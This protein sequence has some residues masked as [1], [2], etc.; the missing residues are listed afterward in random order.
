MSDRIPMIPPFRVVSRVQIL[1]EMMDYNHQMMNVPAMWRDTMGALKDGTGVPVVI[2]DTGIPNH[3]DLKPAGGKSFIPG[4]ERDLNGHGTHVAGIVAAIANNSMGVAGIAPD[5]DDW[6]GAVL[7]EQGSGEISQIVAGIRWA[8]DEVG[9]KVISMSLGI[10]DGY[11]IFPELEKAVNYAN[12]QGVA[13]ICAAGNEASGVGQPACYDSTIAVAA[14]NSRKEKAW[15]SN[16]GS[17]IDFAAGGVDI[18]S[19]YL[20]NG[21][22][23]LSGTSMSAPAL[24]GVATLILADEKNDHGKWLTPDE[25]MEKMKRISY[26]VGGDGFDELY[27]NGIPMFR[28][29]IGEPDEPEANPEPPIEQPQPNPPNAKKS[30][31]PC[32]LTW[33]VLKAFSEG[34][35]RAA[36]DGA[37]PDGAILAGLSAAGKFAGM[38]NEARNSE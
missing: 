37:D 18:Y 15:F 13:V 9:A 19:T 25:L 8:V 34:A 1:A 29:G 32:G 35:D 23:K 31:F 27:G 22:V 36:R 17:E 12:S 3:V 11:P 6:Y 7:D 14:V 2:L 30:A 24:T 21:Y 38:A 5:C 26:D 16:K 20:N 33:K 4:Y 28:S 10:P